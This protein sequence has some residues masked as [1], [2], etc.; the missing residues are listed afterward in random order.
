MNEPYMKS[1]KKYWLPKM[2]KQYFMAK[3]QKNERQITN[4]RENV[5]TN[6]YFNS[7]EKKEIWKEI[8]GCGNGFIR[9][10]KREEDN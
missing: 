5:Y 3:C 2:K 9:T 8:S 7:E 4:L 6:W 10:R 1:F